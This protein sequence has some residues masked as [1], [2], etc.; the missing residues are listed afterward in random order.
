MTADDSR[1]IQ[2]GYDTQILEGYKNALNHSILSRAP[3]SWQPF[4]H[5][6]LPSHWQEWLLPLMGAPFLWAH[7]GRKG[8]L[9]C[10]KPICR[11]ANAVCHC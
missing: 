9:V 6:I 10:T 7:Y 11:A 3:E 2:I 5:S 1:L 8:H 4:L